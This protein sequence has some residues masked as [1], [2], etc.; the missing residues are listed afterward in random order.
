MSLIRVKFIAIIGKL[1]SADDTTVM[2][3]KVEVVSL[4]LSETTIDV[5][6]SYKTI[7]TVLIT[8]GRSFIYIRKQKG[9]KIEP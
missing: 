9:P 2:I 1:M 6:T 8:F 7:W 5:S 3:R 4:V